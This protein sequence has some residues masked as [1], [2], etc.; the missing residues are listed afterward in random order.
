MVVCG[1]Q[2]LAFVTTDGELY[3]SGK[4]TI[5]H[6]QYKDEGGITIPIKVMSLSGHVITSV[7]CGLAHMVVLTKEGT[8]F[9]RNYLKFF[10]KSICLWQI[11]SRF[12]SSPN[13]R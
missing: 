12:C 8:K 4:G 13:C 5:G 3:T 1:Y 6:P 11:K 10:R 2:C 9:L 7:S